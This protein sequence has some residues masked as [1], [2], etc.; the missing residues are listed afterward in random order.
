MSKL[1]Y[2][3]RSG[4]PPLTN[5]PPLETHDFSL[6]PRNIEEYYKSLTLLM[7]EHK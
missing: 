1:L 7:K 4:V 3:Y 2:I 6:S 5:L